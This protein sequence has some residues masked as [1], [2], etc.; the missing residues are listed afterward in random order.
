[1]KLAEEEQKKRVM[2][3]ITF[4]VQDLKC[5]I[6]SW[7]EDEPFICSAKKGAVRRLLP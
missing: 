5:V 2:M 4:R 1:M 6:G 7:S 3:I